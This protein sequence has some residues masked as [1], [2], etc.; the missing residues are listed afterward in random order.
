M[1]CI[2]VFR[3]HA[4]LS[5][6]L[7]SQSFQVFSS[8]HKPFKNVSVL[9]I[10]LNSDVERKLL[11]DL[12][13]NNQVLY[14]HFAPPCGT[15]SAARNIRM[16]KLS[17]GPPPLRSLAMPMGLEDLSDSNQQRVTLAN[18]LYTFVAE[19]VKLLDSKNIGWSIEN[20]SSS[21]MWVTEPMQ[22]LCKLLG[23]KLCA[24]DFDT[25][26]FQAARLKR[27]ALWTN[28]V[29]L[30]QL[31]RK[32]DGSHTHEPWGRVGND[33]ATALECA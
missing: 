28:I 3:G 1:V 4:Q 2:E 9:Q 13:D 26:M 16:H 31:E 20:P 32:C 25:C 19:A 7:R 27:T 17:H 5:K 24:F 11:W 6:S 22:S 33:F 29:Q 14:V 15:A 30:K 8:D 10:D 23:S 21:L 12:V 18:S